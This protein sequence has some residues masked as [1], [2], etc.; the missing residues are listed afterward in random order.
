[1]AKPTTLIGTHLYV[2]LGDGAD[3]E[4]FTHPVMINTDRGFQLQSSG[5]SDM[6]YDPTEPDAPV[7][8]DYYK[9]SMSAQITGSGVLDL[10]SLSTFFDWHASDEAKNVQVWFG[11]ANSDHI[12]G[13]FKLTDFQV[14]APGG[15]GRKTATVSITL[16][17]AGPLV[18]TPYAGG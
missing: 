11:D 16:K 9:T 8:E 3:P 18:Y 6:V 10:A 17:S 13:P 1:M 2:K 14:T 4:V 7:W 15:T 12:D 5:Q